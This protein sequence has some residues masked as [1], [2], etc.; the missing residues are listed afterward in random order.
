MKKNIYRGIAIVS[1]VIGGLALLSGCQVEPEPDPGPI[2]YNITYTASLPAGGTFGGA[3][4]EKAEENG[5]VSFTVTTNNG[6][7]LNSV[8]WETAAGSPTTLTATGTGTYLFSMPA[9]DVIVTATFTK[10]AV[11]PTFYDI[12]YVADPPEGGSFGGTKPE[13][14][15][16]DD[17][18]EFTVT[19]NDG[20][21]LTGVSYTA[22]AGDGTPTQIT[23]T[24][25]LGTYSFTMPSEN[26][27]VTATFTPNQYT[28][29]YTAD[30]EG[31]GTFAG[32]KPVTATIGTEVSF[33]VAA[34]GNNALTK[35]EWT[36]TGGS[37]TTLTASGGTYTF[38]M[39]AADVEVT[40]TFDTLG[41]NERA[42][43]YDVDP[44]GSGTFGTRPPKAEI[45]TTV[46]FT[47]EENPG[48]TLTGVSYTATAG[49]GTPTQ[50]TETATP[51]TYSFTMPDAHITV[52]ATFTPISYDITYTANLSAGGVFA[53]T[54]P[55]TATV[56]TKVEFTVT[57]NDGYTLTGVTWT[58]DEG[59]ATTITATGGTYSFTMPAANVEVTATFTAIEYNIT[60]TA[61]PDG[62]GTFA[63]TKP[64]KA[65]VG[66][67]VEFTVAAED[68]Y[69]LTGV[70][71]T[72]AG[73]T[74]TTIT[75][76][77]GTYSFTMP[78]A[79]VEVTATFVIP[80]QAPV[81]Q[82]GT[83]TVANNGSV[84]L[85]RTTD[86]SKT[87][88]ATAIG[89]TEPLAWAIT[90]GG[91]YAE[92]TGG[93]TGASVTILPKGGLGA[94]T[95]TVTASGFNATGTAATATT[96]FTVNVVD[97]LLDWN[98]ATS[99]ITG[100]TIGA[101]A[102]VPAGYSDI[103]FGSRNIATAIN[104]D[105][106]LTVG[107][108]GGAF[109]IGST[110]ASA[111]ADSS[112]T[113]HRP[114]QFDL[115]D[116][117]FRLTVVYSDA[118]ITSWL[119]VNINNNSF[120]G[121][122]NSV[123]GGDLN[124]LAQ[125][126]SVTDTANGGKSLA[127]SIFGTGNGGNNYTYEPNRM[128]LT[129]TPSLRIGTALAGTNLRA[130]NSLKTAF[131]GL[132]SG[133]TDVSLNIT[134]I[135]LEKIAETAG[136]KNDVT[137]TQAD[138]GKISV[139]R[140]AAAQGTV[141]TVTGTP[142][143]GYKLTGISVDGTPATL[144][145]N[146]AGF[147]MPATAVEVTGTFAEDPNFA[148]ILLDWNSAYNE[149]PNTANLSDTT[150]T[151]SGWGEITFIRKNNTVGVENGEIK[152]NDGRLIIGSAYGQS[153][154]GTLHVPGQFDL[155]SGTFR[156][157]LEY[158]VGLPNTASNYVLRVRINENNMDRSVL[159][160]PEIRT[161]WNYN[162]LQ[163]TGTAGSVTQ[164]SSI[165]NDTGKVAM[166]FTPS[167]IFAAAET[168][169]PFDVYAPAGNIAGGLTNGLK[170]LETAFIG[171]M[172]PWQYTITAIRLERVP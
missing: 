105:G 127:G 142:Q 40:A 92:F 74:A 151:Y 48:Y 17:P 147:I 84:T 55:E 63:G 68:G 103:L 165:Y 46:E 150:A 79:N 62:S 5:T 138:N 145:E 113:A 69:T 152:V 143:P 125:F 93:A 60:Y 71:W 137:V 164:V 98:A 32:T 167:T 171:L 156:L 130:Y 38:D 135:R 141:V 155:S 23:E 61:D 153:T 51:G 58:P 88:T 65:A 85:D 119:R 31:S 44:P 4:P 11:T 35:V 118:A 18:V 72:P 13:E 66:T 115:S 39:P 6:Y 28:I 86:T 20:Y 52:T 95:V 78:A 172:M 87:L 133:G 163:L 170:S 97:L 67:E 15:E 64:E 94:V 99:P 53:G 144:F 47:V 14:A 123:F 112:G 122:A 96:T 158:K 82:E 50:I 59:T 161:C 126:T 45:G 27:T 34:V 90:A 21:T 54:K 160:S 116:G 91:D 102:I 7:T 109:V 30:P 134:A 75:E 148:N 33:T 166:T 169:G 29:T 124:Q 9:A 120:G 140:A 101:G 24:A 12:E 77:G 106:S 3:K 136:T 42:I 111:T 121:Y 154:S 80:V 19:A 70:T 162:D 117:T 49:G 10:D 114:G 89:A 57:A 159:A 76:S 81:V 2:K 107:G 1:L 128:V 41:E 131:I 73:G 83:A 37:P 110:I 56:N 36:P 100:S 22:T 8:S 104:N 168:T 43:E 146:T 25:T 132:V 26:I 108:G 139:D 157:T 149:I 129:F 16:E